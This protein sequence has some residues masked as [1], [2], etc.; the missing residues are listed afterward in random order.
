MECTI[1]ADGKTKSTMIFILV[2]V[3]YI[4]HVPSVTCVP[5]NILEKTLK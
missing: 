1:E 5:L 3:L 4:V 2:N